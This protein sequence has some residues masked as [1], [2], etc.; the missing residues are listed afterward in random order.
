MKVVLIAPGPPPFG[1]MA[2]QAEALERHLRAEGIEAARV[3]TNP[4]LRGRIARA[5]GVRTV[6]QTGVYLASLA[7]A[8]PGADV[9]HVLAAS[10]W[11]FFLRVVP[12]V[13]LGRCLGCRVVLNYRGGAAPRFFARWR[14]LL[15]AVLRLAHVVVVPS[16]FLE[17]VFAQHGLRARVIS[18]IVD[19]ERFRFRKRERLSPNLLVSRN[20]EPV[21]NVELALKAF[22]RV[23]AKYPAARLEILGSGTQE[24]Q[25][26]SWVRARNLKDVYFHGAVPNEDVPRYLER[27][28]ILLNPSRVDNMPI[29]LLE[30]FAAGVPVVSTRVGG[31]ADLVG[32][33]ESALLVEAGDDAA[34]AEKIEILLGHPAKVRSITAKAREICQNFSWNAVRKDWLAAYNGQ[35]LA[36]SQRAPA[37]VAEV[38]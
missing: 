4:P 5:R 14:G 16:P 23:K 27:A 1:G 13:L 21:Y 9:V 34:M 3:V 18:N 31:I 26:K 8:L 7:R 2:L 38:K 20:L 15:G 37:P 29:N 30:A 12:A 28:D 35:G 32:D 19:L 22:A 6:C 17:R 11:Y 24:A 33:E 36:S 10:Y 25:L